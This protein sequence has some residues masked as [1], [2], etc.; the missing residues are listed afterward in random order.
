MLPCLENQMFMELLICTIINIA[1]AMNVTT[2][3]RKELS[4]A[5]LGVVEDS[6]QAGVTWKVQDWSCKPVN[7]ASMQSP[8]PDA[9]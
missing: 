7:A 9:G 1:D 6:T 8:A 4:V 5:G 2:G 3:T